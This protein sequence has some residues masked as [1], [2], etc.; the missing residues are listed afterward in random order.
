MVLDIV[1]GATRELLSDVCPPVA[2]VLVEGN[3]DCLFIVGPFPFLQ[4]NVKVVDIAFTTLLALSTGQMCSNLC[5]LSTVELALLTE[6]VVFLSGPRTLPFD[7]GR[8]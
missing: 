5:P 6:D 1:V 3:E 2:V 7:E 8:T 4:L